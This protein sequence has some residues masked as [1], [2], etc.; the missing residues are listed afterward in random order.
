MYGQMCECE[1]R[2]VTLP[3]HLRRD[4]LHEMPRLT[5][6]RPFPH[7]REATAL[8]AT[9]NSNAVT[10][11]GSHVATSTTDYSPLYTVIQY[12]ATYNRRPNT[13]LVLHDPPDSSHEITKKVLIVVIKFN[14]DVDDGLTGYRNL[15][16]LLVRSQNKASETSVHLQV[17]LICKV[18]IKKKKRQPKLSFHPIKE[19]LMLFASE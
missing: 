11:Q 16:C 14:S 8:P 2:T 4:P 5:V 12:T 9:P 17:D 15:S 7:I 1:I 3:P 10:V 13:I 19:T 18:I 6:H